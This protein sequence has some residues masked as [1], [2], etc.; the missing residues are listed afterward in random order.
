[1]TMKCLKAAL[2]LSLSLTLAACG[3]QNSPDQS[4]GLSSQAVTPSQRYIVVF[5]DQRLPADTAKRVS[6]AGGWV[7]KAVTETGVATISGNAAVR[8]KLERDSAVLAV[9]LEH[10]YTLPPT[11]RVAADA[12]N[13]AGGYSATAAD[14]LY[15]YQWDMRR[16]GAQVAANRVGNAQSRITVGVLDVGV[17][18]DHPDMVGQ[19]A[20]SKGTNYCQETGKDGTTGYPVYS[21]LIDF[22]A[23]PEW[24]PADGCDTA[25]A[26]FEDHGTHVAGTV[27]GA[28]GGGAIV[29]VAPGAKIAAYKVFDRYRFTDA[30][31]KLQDGVGGFDGP[32]FDAI[33]DAANRGVNIINMSLGST[34]DRSNKDDNASWLAWQ[35]VMNYADKKGTLIIASAGNDAEN[36]NGNIAHIP[37]DV[38]GI[39]SVSATGVTVLATDAK[40]NLV[41]NGPDVLAFYSNYGASTDIAAPGGDCGTN[42]ANG[43]SWCDSSNRAKRPADW[44]T[45]LILSSIINADGTPGYDWLAGTSMASPHVAGVAALVKAQHPEFS[46]NQLKAYLKRTAENVGQKQG[47]GS[48]LANADLATR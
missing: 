12:S 41:A 38:P 21:K 4:A 19:I 25:K 40:G 16:I 29:G 34:L 8:A 6:A 30:Q 24:S 43:L 20:F 33:V 27:A 2:A 37:S 35:R 26:I 3:Q 14:T 44:F 22:D 31:G 15:G 48:G 36:S 11:E 45:H 5:K 13:T 42:P 10:L 1:M 9:G 17:M 32:I 23:H 28:V 46:T 7:Q 39:M 47:F 18:S